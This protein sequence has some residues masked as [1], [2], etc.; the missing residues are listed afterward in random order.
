[1][2]AKRASQHTSRYD[3]SD[4][5]GEEVDECR[6]DIAHRAV[7]RPAPR[8]KTKGY[9]LGEAAVNRGFARERYG[10]VTLAFVAGVF[11]SS[12]GCGDDGSHSGSGG[13]PG[14]GGALDGGPLFCPDPLDPM[15]HY[16]SDDPSQCDP[17][18]LRCTSEQNGFDN[19]C[20]CG[21]IDKGAAGC[22]DPQ[23]PDVRYFSRN[24][25][26]CGGTPACGIN[27]LVFD[28]ACGCGCVLSG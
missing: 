1:M 13:S 10:L 19:A 9:L 23:N 26:E 14:D 16:L 2:L 20:G 28:N 22:P 24:P 15:V 18:D 25:A 4:V 8:G 12:L 5:P 17:E 7:V 11:A 27:E 21:C 3:G 6:V